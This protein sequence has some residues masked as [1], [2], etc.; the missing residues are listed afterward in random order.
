MLTLPP[1]EA[2]AKV[3]LTCKHVDRCPAVI[4]V[5]LSSTLCDVMFHPI[6][7][8]GD[9]YAQHER[10]TLNELPSWNAVTLVL[11]MFTESTDKRTKP[12]NQLT[13]TKV[14]GMHPHNRG[15]GVAKRWAVIY[16]KCRLPNV[17]WHVFLL[18]WRR[19]IHCH[20]WTS[21]FEQS[22]ILHALLPDGKTRVIGTNFCGQAPVWY[23]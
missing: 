17:I 5:M 4:I 3:A 14:R 11:V 1:C 15:G 21:S 18:V 22:R 16:Q 20:G 2:F 10:C 19:L 13:F 7:G 12:S 6:N 9:P 23:A 8:A